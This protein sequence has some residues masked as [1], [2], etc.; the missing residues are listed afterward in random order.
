M[1]SWAWVTKHKH[2]ASNH[3]WVGLSLSTSYRFSDSCEYCFVFLFRTCVIH[4]YL[5]VRSSVIAH[6]LI[7]L[8]FSFHFSVE[9][10]AF[11]QLIVNTILKEGSINT[12]YDSYL[13]IVSNH[14]RIDNVDELALKNPYLNPRFES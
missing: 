9:S 12:R 10:I 7:N 11:Q 2:F 1:K 5:I 8:G 13:Q 14:T 4:F 3:D 6:Y